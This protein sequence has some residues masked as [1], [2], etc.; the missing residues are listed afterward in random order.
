MERL[1]RYSANFRAETSQLEDINLELKL[2][3]GQAS[4]VEPRQKYKDSASLPDKTDAARKLTRQINLATQLKKPLPQ[5]SSESGQPNLGTNFSI[6]EQRLAVEH[7]L[8]SKHLEYKD[9]F[10]AARGISRVFSKQPDMW[11]VLEGAIARELRLRTGAKST[12]PGVKY[13]Y[14][15]ISTYLQNVSQEN[16]A[17]S[18]AFKRFMDVQYHTLDV[19]SKWQ[20]CQTFMLS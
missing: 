1:Q 16:V 9:L 14:M 17:F 10:L 5:K 19:L 8:G 7:V 13:L 6:E 12:K 2:F 18:T 3:E 4:Q 15:A 11:K 20:I